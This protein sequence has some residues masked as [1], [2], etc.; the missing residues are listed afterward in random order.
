MYPKIS[1]VTPS[2]N[3]GPYLEQT[4]QSVLDQ[5]YPNLEYII[6]DGGSTDESVEIIKKYERYLTYWVSEP[7]KGQSEALNKGLAKCTGEIFNWINSDDYLEPGAL[8]K[9]GEAFKNTNADIVCGYTRIFEEESGVEILRHR[10]TLFRSVEASLIQQRINQPAMYYRLPIINDLGGINI[11]LHYSMDLE[12][13]FRYLCS[14]GQNRMIFMDDLFAHFRI[15]GKSKTGVNEERFRSEEKAIWYYLLSLLHANKL[16][17][18]FF[19]SSVNYKPSKPWDIKTINC[20]QIEI[21]LSQHYLYPFLKSRNK[22]LGRLALNTLFRSGRLSLSF[23]NLA[24]FTKLYVGNIPFR[25]FFK[26]HA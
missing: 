22:I 1:I 6:I 16:W 13:W 17:V 23:Q 5:N 8:L 21:E 7:D 2:F 9:I 20:N 25:K 24:V 14:R 19:K 11:N 12:L 15:H 10:T 26:N 3:Q 4:I 18:L